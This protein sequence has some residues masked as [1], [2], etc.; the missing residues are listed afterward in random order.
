LYPPQIAVI[1]GA[2]AI[3]MLFT[4]MMQRGLKLNLAWHLKLL[5]VPL[6][7]YLVWQ[8]APEAGTQYIYFDF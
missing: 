8:L 6:C 2:I 3:V 1:F 4:F 5:L 7:W